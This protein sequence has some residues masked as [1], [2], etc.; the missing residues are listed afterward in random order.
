MEKTSSEVIVQDICPSSNTLKFIMVEENEG[1]E[2]NTLVEIQ[3]KKRHND[4]VKSRKRVRGELPN[5]KIPREEIF[6]CDV[7]DTE[8]E[9]MGDLQSHVNT[10]HLH[11]SPT[12][13]LPKTVV[14]A[15][16]S[17]IFR[18]QLSILIKKYADANC[19]SKT[20]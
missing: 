6:R 12:K 20:E 17:H 18:I 11:A 19:D 16:V 9:S 8:F 1:D 10:L 7:C 4:K 5:I 14:M 15:K 3:H 13:S 2:E